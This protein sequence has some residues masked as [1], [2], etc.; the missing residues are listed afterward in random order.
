MRDEYSP[1]DLIFDKIK[2]IYKK[3]LLGPSLKYMNDVKKSNEAQINLIQ[4]EYGDENSA[5]KHTN[6]N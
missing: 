6:L 4:S 3:E 5:N 2:Q 1:R